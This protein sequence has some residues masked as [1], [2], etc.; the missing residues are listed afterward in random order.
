M[1]QQSRGAPAFDS[2]VLLCLVSS[3]PLKAGRAREIVA[4]GGGISVQVLDEIANVLRRK[5]GM[6]RPDIRLF[7][8]TVRDLLTVQDISIEAHDAGLAL[9][10]RYGLSV[11]DAMIAASAPGA[12]C[13]ILWSEDMHDG[14]LVQGKLRV[15]NLFRQ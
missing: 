13:D 10:E 3:D 14:L 11:H 15:T 5:A 1:G 8:S 2:N 12:G 7:L 6:P 9:A 4:K